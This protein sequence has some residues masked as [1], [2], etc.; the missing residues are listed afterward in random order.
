MRFYSVQLLNM[1][2]P[3]TIVSENPMPENT[4]CA[5]PFEVD[6]F[7]FTV[8]PTDT[9]M[10]YVQQTLYRQSLPTNALLK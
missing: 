7:R 9:G 8:A 3:A 1:T 2:V 6:A 10:L 4:G 5:T